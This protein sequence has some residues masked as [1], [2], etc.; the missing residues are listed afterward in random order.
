[1]RHLVFFLY[2]F[3]PFVIKTILEDYEVWLLCFLSD[4][5]LHQAWNRED[6][7]TESHPALPS[8]SQYS[9]LMLSQDHSFY[10]DILK[11][12]TT[13]YIPQTHSNILDEVF[14]EKTVLFI[15]QK[16]FN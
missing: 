6:P 15:D 12:K 2:D 7:N 16:F 3:L 10:S 14:S 13:P 11:N 4:K 9:L 5:G 1:M 8:T